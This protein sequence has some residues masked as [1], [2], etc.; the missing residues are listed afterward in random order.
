MP[1]PDNDDD[2]T[3]EGWG[4]EQIRR[5][6]QARF[7]GLSPEKQLRMQV[8]LLRFLTHSNIIARSPLKPEDEPK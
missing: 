8:E 4:D 6:L 3:K 7:A 2:D 1:P 5:A